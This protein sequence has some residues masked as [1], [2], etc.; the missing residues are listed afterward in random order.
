MPLS[1]R[2]PSGETEMIFMMIGSSRTGSRLSSSRSSR[3]ARFLLVMIPP[4]ALRPLKREQPLP[5][6]GAAPRN[7]S[8]RRATVRAGN[9]V[10]ERRPAR[11]GQAV[12]R[13]GAECR[14]LARGYGATLPFP[15]EATA[16]PQAGAAVCPV[17]SCFYRL[18]WFVA[19]APLRPQDDLGETVNLVRPFQAR[20]RIGHG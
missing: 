11:A 13:A 7:L 14:A 16:L 10:L 1:V 18:R 6:G 19:P 20:N 3:R 2:V 4:L 17:I 5:R 9:R 12:P 8:S 15:A